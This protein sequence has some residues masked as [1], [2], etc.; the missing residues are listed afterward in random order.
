M[1][2]TA[3]AAAQAYAAAARAV[4]DAAKGTAQAKTPGDGEGDF[5][6]ALQQA[7]ASVSGTIDKA[8]ATTMAQVAGKAD[9]VDVV[10]AVAETEVALRTLVSVRDRVIAT[11]QEIM[12]MPI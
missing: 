5:G 12:R 11:Y 3:S 9:V 1:T 4:A 8:E 10:T 2:T 7:V 6:A